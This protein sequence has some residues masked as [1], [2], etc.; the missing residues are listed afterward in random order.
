MIEEENG[1]EVR[2]YHALELER[3]RVNFFPSSWT[4]VHPVDENSPMFELSQEKFLSKS[5]EFLIILKAFDD[6]FSS[7]VFSR[8]SYMAHQISWGRKF[9]NIHDFKRKGKPAV[10]LDQLSAT[11]EA[12]LNR[13]GHVSPH[14]ASTESI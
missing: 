3:N 14:Q 11:V 6:T 4:I 8:Y 5:P 2:K 9:I 1:H 12:P 13:T 7:T 10:R